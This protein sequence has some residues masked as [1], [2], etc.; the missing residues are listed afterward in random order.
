MDVPLNQMIQDFWLFLSLLLDFNNS[1][2][3]QYCNRTGAG[4]VTYP[5]T[6]QTVFGIQ[7]SID[8]ITYGNS[9]GWNYHYV[10]AVNSSNCILATADDFLHYFLIIC[11]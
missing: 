7:V 2:I 9:A 10:Y 5:I 4:I 3:L 1:L 8:R 6:C 11:C